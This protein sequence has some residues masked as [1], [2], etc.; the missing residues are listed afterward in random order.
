MSLFT[1][2]EDQN[3]QFSVKRTRTDDGLRLRLHSSTDE[4]V[5][6][7]SYKVFKH[8]IVPSF[9]QYIIDFSKLEEYKKLILQCFF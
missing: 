1:L 3:R 9:K 8:F 2:H 5:K 4:V 6:L 7:V